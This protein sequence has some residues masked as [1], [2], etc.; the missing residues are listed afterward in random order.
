MLHPVSRKP[1]SWGRVL[2]KKLA[3]SLTP[4]YYSQISLKYKDS[5]KSLDCYLQNFT[6]SLGALTYV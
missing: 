3:M 6:N 5:Y 4:Q 2:S 1:A